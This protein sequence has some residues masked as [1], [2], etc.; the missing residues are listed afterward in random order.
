VTT[1]PLDLAQLLEIE[2]EVGP[3]RLHWHPAAKKSVGTLLLGHGAGGGVGAGDLIL[4]TAAAVAAGLDVGLFEQPYRVA[5]RRA[6]A[7]AGQLD[8]ALTALIES[9][10][11]KKVIL[12][13]RS[14]GARVAC[15][16][17]AQRGLAVGKGGGGRAPAPKIVGV[18]ALAF[19]LHPPGRPERSRL[20]ELLAAPV[21]RL[22]VQ[23]ERDTFGGAAALQAEL[24]SAGV[25]ADEVQVLTAAGADHALRKGVDVDAVIEWAR[26]R[27]RPR[28]RARAAQ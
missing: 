14:S 8:R 5:G 3:A 24:A 12:G 9:L 22:V 4:V 2:T 1:A 15:R 27:F 20:D 17:A 10:D 23:G 16:V 25:A 7:P 26:D 18:L 13:G 19:P 28:S 6:P 21:P 11:V